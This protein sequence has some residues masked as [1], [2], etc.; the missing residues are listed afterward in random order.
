M[1]GKGVQGP[2]EEMECRN[3]PELWRWPDT[4]DLG[5]VIYPLYT[6]TSLLSKAGITIYSVPL[7]L[8]KEKN[9]QPWGTVN[10]R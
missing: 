6:Y 7:K 1:E 4:S 10:A 2:G 3:D 5:Q 9:E 8:L